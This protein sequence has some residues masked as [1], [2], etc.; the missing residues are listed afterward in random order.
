MDVVPDE[1]D[2]NLLWVYLVNHRPPLDPAVDAA[3]VGADSAIEIFKTQVGSSTMEWVKTVEDPSIIVTP[4]DILGGSNGQE[5]WFTNDNSVKVGLAR[6][7][8]LLFGVKS[9]WVGYCHVNTGCKVAADE[10]YSSNGIVRATD[11]NVWVASTGGGHITVHEQ[12]P[13]KTLVPTEI[14]KIGRAIDNLSLAPDGSIIAATIPN[15]LHFILQS[16]KDPSIPTS[17]SAH[18]ISVNKGQSSYFGENYKVEKIF[19][20][21]G[22]ML[23]SAASTAAEYEGKLYLHGVIAPRLLICNLPAQKLEQ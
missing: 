14:I 23:G 1:H 22:T 6:P 10:L 7:L 18:R 16:A 19:E 13:D 20:E 11:G 17:A 2:A 12:Q 5:F 9:T 3:K 21:D 8:H 4:N 15:A